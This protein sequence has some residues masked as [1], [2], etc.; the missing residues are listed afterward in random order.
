MSVL[1]EVLPYAYLY[2][3][4]VHYNQAIYCQFQALGS[5]Q[6]Y[7]KDHKLQNLDSIW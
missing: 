7:R 2:G 4:C 5:T 3:C 1:K 6:T